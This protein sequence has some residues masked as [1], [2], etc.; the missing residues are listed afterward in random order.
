MELDKAVAVESMH[1]HQSMLDGIDAYC[2][3]AYRRPTTDRPV[4]W[5]QGQSRV[6][7]YTNS[8]SHGPAVL[9][10]PSLVN[11]SYI[12]DLTPRHSLMTHLAR[13]GTRPFLLDWGDVAEAERGLTL[14]DYI[15]RLC[16]AIRAVQ[17]VVPGPLALTGYCMGGNL[18]LAAALQMPQ[19]VRA[20]ATL[21]TPWDFWA[22]N[23]GHGAMMR[24]VEPQLRPLIQE[25]G[26]LPLDLLQAMFASL[27]PTLSGRK[28]IAFSRLDYRTTQARDFVAVED[29]ANDGVPL[30]GPVAMECLFDWYGRN[31][32]VQGGWSIGG[33][34]IRPQDLTIPCLC[35]VPER[36][37]IVPAASSLALAAAIPK[38]D[39]R[40][41]R[42][43]HVGMLLSERSWDEVYAPLAAWIRG[44]LDG[45]DG[46][47]RP[48]RR[49][50]KSRGL[51]PQVSE[52]SSHSP[53]KETHQ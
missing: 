40:M 52:T 12:L 31:Q 28:F 50:I 41:I 24:A 17:Q 45:F 27:D 5:T 44:S 36:D 51:Y 26:Y 16:D 46:C 48:R 1:R 32:P 25:M 49:T 13:L 23:H 9:V 7:D 4:I 15:A 47:V 10:V 29:W 53:L 30:S 21:A 20:L 6:F 43:G 35:M 37:R 3:H 39:L 33:N 38:A 14:T 42:G 18:A 8:R 34:P 19:Q 11:R 2:R 22:G